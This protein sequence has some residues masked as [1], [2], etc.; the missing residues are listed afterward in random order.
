[1]KS[2]EAETETQMFMQLPISKMCMTLLYIYRPVILG[3]VYLLLH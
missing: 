3:I 2:S 1:M